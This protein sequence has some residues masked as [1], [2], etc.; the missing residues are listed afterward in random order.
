MHKPTSRRFR[1]CPAES[2][3]L[4]IHGLA[5][6]GY[7][8][9]VFEAWLFPWK[10]LSGMRLSVTMQDYPVPIDVNQQA[11]DIDVRPYATTITYSTI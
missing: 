7:Q 3:N 5:I 6:L 4:A 9:G 8:N 11:A 10:I 1:P 2:G